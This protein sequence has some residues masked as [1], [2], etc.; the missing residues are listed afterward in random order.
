MLKV[1]PGVVLENR[2]V[3]GKGKGNRAGIVTLG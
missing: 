3:E 1:F 2:R